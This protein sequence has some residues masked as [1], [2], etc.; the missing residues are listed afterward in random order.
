[1]RRGQ[2]GG[3]AERSEKK[4]QEGGGALRGTHVK[5]GGHQAHPGC[6]V[7]CWVALGG[8]ENG[9]G[10]AR[11]VGRGSQH[12]A[13]LG[14][15][16]VHGAAGRGGGPHE[17]RQLLHLAQ[18]GVKLARPLRGG[19]LA[20]KQAPRVQH[21]R[22]LALHLCGVKGRAVGAVERQRGHG[23]ALRA[24]FLAPCPP[25]PEKIRGGP[26]PGPRGGGY[27]ARGVGRRLGRLDWS[28]AEPRQQ[29]RYP[30]CGSSGL[31]R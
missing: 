7:A 21:L 24:E 31:C 1:M 27:A 15:V 11:V 25:P 20:Q 9:V 3:G 14:A 29:S 26:G 16:K 4:Q 22:P 10:V 17:L 18:L 30:H 5:E 2:R 23:R 8:G 13:A 6:A 12:L 28:P 19:A